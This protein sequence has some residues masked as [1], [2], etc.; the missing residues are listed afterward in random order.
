MANLTIGTLAEKG[1]VGVETVRFYQR[2]GLM[3]VP[4]KGEGIRRYGDEDLKRLRFI[5]SAQQ[6]GF[7]LAQIE[8]LVGM[9][10]QE[11]RPRVLA[12]AQERLREIDAR[13]KE[14][15]AVRS[16]LKGLARD[17]ASG[18]GEACPIL[19]SFEVG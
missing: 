14:L 5:R 9:S 16:A 4:P 13:I 8:E 10:A 7:T 11:D 6:A 17:C 19:K 15:E 3:P 2:K 1:A 18:A 12:L